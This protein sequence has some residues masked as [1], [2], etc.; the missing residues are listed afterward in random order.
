MVKNCENRETF[1]VSLLSCHSFAAT[2]LNADEVAKLGRARCS[3]SS[4]SN[5]FQQRMKGYYFSLKVCSNKLHTCER[6]NLIFM[7]VDSNFIFQE[8][9]MIVCY[10]LFYNCEFFL[11]PQS[12]FFYVF[13]CPLMFDFAEFLLFFSVLAILQKVSLSLFKLSS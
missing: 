2:L 9:A 3:I 12:T 11:V 10:V 13:F 5:K 4:D 8:F 7:V 6:N 1:K